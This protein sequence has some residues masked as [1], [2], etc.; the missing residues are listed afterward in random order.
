MLSELEIRDDDLSDRLDQTRRQ[1]IHRLEDYLQTPAERKLREHQVDVMQS[2]H[3]FLRSGGTSGYISLPTGSGKT[4]LAAEFIRVLGL[5]TVILSPTQTILEQTHTQVT[6]K[7]APE[8][9][10]TNYYAQEKDLSGKVLNTT[11]QSMM[12]L[13]DNDQIAP[14][15][16]ELLI[17]DEAHTALGE[18]RHTIFRKFP[19]ALMIGLTATPYFA[20][21][22]GY[23]QRG[24]VEEGESW[25]GLF[26]NLIHEMTLEEG[27]ER[28]ILSP[29]EVHLLRTNIQVGDVQIQSTGEYNKTSLERWL[30]VQARDYLAVAMIAG[31]DKLPPG[32]K[33]SQTQAEEVEAI[34]EKIRRQPTVIFGL[35][36][37]HIEDLKHKLMDAGRYSTFTVHSGVDPEKRAGI[38]KS[39]SEGM[40]DNVLAVDVLRLGWDAPIV[41]TGIF[42]SHTRSGIVAVQEIG[43]ILRPSPETGKERALAIQLVDD[44]QNMA[45][46]PILIPNIFDPYYVLKGTQ[47]GLETSKAGPGTKRDVPKITFSGLEI[48]SI[49]QETRTQDLLQTRFS[50]ADTLEVAQI[51]DNL[52]EDIKLKNPDFSFLD[53]CKELSNQL[54]YQV[55]NERQL[56]TLQAISSI[57]TNVSSAGKK[58]ILFLYMKTIL[59]A[60]EP[61]F[62]GDK[63]WDQDIL[64][65]A[66]SNIFENITGLTSKYAL[67]TQI[68]SLSQRGAAKFISSLENIPQTWVVASK[69]HELTS[70]VTEEFEISGL[71]L[72]E[73]QINAL[74]EELSSKTC[75]EAGPIVTY[76]N[77]RIYLGKISE[78]TGDDTEEEV[79]NLSLRDDLEKVMQKLKGTERLAIKMKYGLSSIADGEMSYK[80]IGDILGCTSQ[81]SSMLEAKGLR[82][83][84]NPRLSRILWVYINP[85]YP[86][87]EKVEELRRGSF[88]PQLEEQPLRTVPR[89]EVTTKAGYKVLESRMKYRYSSMSFWEA[90]IL[91]PFSN[92]NQ[93]LLVGKITNMADLLEKTN[94]E[95]LAID[96]VNPENVHEIRSRI[97]LFLKRENE[98]KTI[99]DQLIEAEN[100][101]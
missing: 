47:T 69:H 21:L 70:M 5:K 101:K 99:A 57:D 94:T 14:E 61:Y 98:V 13:L 65:S 27:I 92:L 72:T 45:Q 90:G 60:L 95:L 38:L 11:Y 79:M 22:E 25:T 3:K 75:I 83:L 32:I 93:S 62:K 52:I 18:Q 80:K 51:I 39:F 74:A 67:P 29:L 64:H 35:S 76:I 66:I 81:Y 23:R 12:L 34:H 46:A 15:N 4:G 9:D 7:F 55:R 26:K 28:G 36:I 59:S 50:Q 8:A 82:H 68:H 100:F 71:N 89:R 40:I 19:N 41:R 77:Y 2:F 42:L 20:Q 84:R 96:G 78:E 53:V 6:Q 37:D 54:P 31:A 86:P 43:R 10:I 85:N 97:E 73:K 58:A 16:I 30:R 87:L 48:D 56:Q 33:L 1:S 91:G 49:I 24:L 17:C 63:D 44:F 88:L